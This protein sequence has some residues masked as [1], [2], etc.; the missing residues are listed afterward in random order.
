MPPK[1]GQWDESGSVTVFWDFS[2]LT[3]SLTLPLL[4][5]LPPCYHIASSAASR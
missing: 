5:G 3:I 1:G 4:H 2:Q